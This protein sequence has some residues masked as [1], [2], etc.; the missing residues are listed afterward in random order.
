MF[1]FFK[2]AFALAVAVAVGYFLYEILN[3]TAIYIMELV[4]IMTGFFLLVKWALIAVLVIF[5][6]I[7]IGGLVFAWL[8]N[9]LVK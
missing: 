9:S 7:Y 6:P 3:Q 4:G 8:Y 1:N 5:L 2:M